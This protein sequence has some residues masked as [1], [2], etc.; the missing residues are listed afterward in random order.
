MSNERRRETEERLGFDSQE[1]RR[2]QEESI[3]RER[4][5]REAAEQVSQRIRQSASY[6]ILINGALGFDALDALLGFFGLAVGSLISFFVGL[7]YVYISAF[8]VRQLRLTVAVLF[9]LLVDMLIGFVPFA[10]TVVDMAFPAS[11]ICRG[12]IQGVVDHDKQKVKMVNLICMTGFFVVAALVALIY[13][14]FKLI[15]PQ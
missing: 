7:G 6:R 9:V 1:E 4:K 15:A 10:G 11:Y 13:C 3:E 8:V 12:L 5:R 2:I 14:L